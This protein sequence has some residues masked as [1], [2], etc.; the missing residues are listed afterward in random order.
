MTEPHRSGLA[1]LIGRPNVGKS[2]LV[3]RLVGAKISITS[4][5]PQTTRHRILGIKN[6]P[7]SQIVYVDTPGLHTA[8][9]SGMDRYMGRITSGSVEGVDVVVLVI[10]ATGWR[11]EDEPALKL[12]T[13]SQVPVVLV[14]NKID[15]LDNRAA[16]LPLIEQCTAKGDFADIVPVSART[17]SN[18]GELEATIGRHLPEQP[19]I[20]PTDQ[21]TDRS[22]RFIA[23][24]LVRE[25]VFNA[26]G[27]EVP[28]ASTVQVE[29]FRRSKGKLR[30]D[31]V[32]WVEKEGQKAILIGKNGARLKEV[33]TRARR[34][35]E[36]FFGG[37]V[38]LG[39]WVKVR[40]GWSDDEAALRR[41]GY[42]DSR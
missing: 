4:R 33:G 31:A 34:A 5:R 19:P 13:A 23:G 40:E 6:G 21:L 42:E 29:Q 8:R 26:Y 17:R 14:I 18:L 36:A 7:N 12:A 30:V 11:P 20:Y 28:Y 41:F 2:T 25:Q 1:T 24:E 3:N 32:V 39:L 16:L 22:E 9:A 10:A 27:Q 38:Y 37:H 35:L 15:L